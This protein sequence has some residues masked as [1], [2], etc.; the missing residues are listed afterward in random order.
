M[1]FSSFYKAGVSTHFSL[2]SQICRFDILFTCVEKRYNISNQLQ[3]KTT[4]FHVILFHW[5][6]CLSACFQK[7]NICLLVIQSLLN[8]QQNA[9]LHRR[10]CW[11]L[12]S[13]SI[14]LAGF[15]NIRYMRL[16]DVKKRTVKYNTRIQSCKDTVIWMACA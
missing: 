13:L 5:L 2:R 3:F 12:C 1:C 8:S 10:S 7:L 6:I 4:R 9:P 16:R 15:T 14:S 11:P